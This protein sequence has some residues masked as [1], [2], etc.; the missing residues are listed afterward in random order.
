MKKTLNSDEPELRKEWRYFELV[1]SE[2]GAFVAK[3]P[4][5]EF[6]WPAWDELLPAIGRK[7]FRQLTNLVETGHGFLEDP[8]N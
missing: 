3:S 7:D 1:P 5:G 8:A 4:I 2:V 6:V